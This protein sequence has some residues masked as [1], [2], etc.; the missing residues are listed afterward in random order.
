[1]KEQ[2]NIEYLIAVLAGIWKAV[3]TAP[4]VVVVTTAICTYLL[5]VWLHLYGGFIMV[6]L[7]SL[8]DTHLAIK[9]CIKSG[10]KY[11]SKKIKRGVLNKISLYITLTALGIALDTIFK[12][13]YN[14]DSY[15]TALIVFAFIALYEA[16]SIIESLEK[17]HPKNPIVARFSRFLNLADKK[18]D[19]KIND[20]LS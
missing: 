20:K 4:L 9:T 14:Y 18:L 12:Q 15:Y 6:A 10:G 13:I 19:D 16:G 2:S 11:E 17:I 1:M 5:D 8:M 7:L 3:S